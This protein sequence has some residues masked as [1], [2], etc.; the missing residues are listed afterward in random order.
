MAGASGISMLAADASLLSQAWPLT[1]A[2]GALGGYV[3]GSMWALVVSNVKHV[4][5]LGISA[6]RE[7]EQVKKTKKKT[8]NT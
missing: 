2:W 8:K 7:D 5:G 1:P 6:R 4:V 3:L